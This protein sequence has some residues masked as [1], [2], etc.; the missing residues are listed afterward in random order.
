[1]KST[2]F[3]SVS[4]ERLSSP[5]QLDQLLK[6]TDPKGWIVLAALGVVL[7]TAIVWGSLGSIP[8]NVGGMGMLVKSGGVFEVITTSSGRITDIA[9][10]AG[11]LVTEGQVIARM[12]QPE[13]TDQLREARSVLATLQSQHRELVA[14]GSS[15]GELQARLLRQQR[16]TVEQSIAAAQ[17]S[18]VWYA[19]KVALQEKLVQESLLVKQTLLN[20]RQQ[21]DATRQQISDGRSQLAQI[22]VKELD[23]RAARADD[24]RAGQIKID[25]QERVIADLERNVKA[26]TEIVAQQTGRILEILTEQG[27]VVTKGEAIVTLDLMGRN[28]KDLEAVIFVP[29]VFGKQIKVGMSALIAP[30]TVKQEEYGLMV[31]RITYVS[32]FPATSRGM[33]RVLKNEKLVG[34]LAGSD[35]PYEVHADLVIDTATASGYKWSSSQGPPLRIQ[36]GT[37][38]M[39]QIGV[40]SRRPIEMVIPL[41]RKSTGL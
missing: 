17:Q 5:E 4:L 23:L 10:A 15:N 2:V 28:V 19:E 12:S 6:V 25:Q 11:D 22:A 31:A 32:D 40:A 34:S 8:Q 16:T 13:L 21:L 39:A 9:L 29:S 7:A 20:T 35:A 3:R 30:S 33:R 37:L 36:S 18:A 38:A 27:A 14:Y 24:V 26:T 41:L 1:M